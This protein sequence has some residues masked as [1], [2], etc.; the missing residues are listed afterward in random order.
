[1]TKR[2]WFAAQALNGVLAHPTRYRPRRNSSSNW[3]EAIAE[4][5]CELAD[6]LIAELEE[7]E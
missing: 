4:E 7:K 5:A 6:A 2:E 3:H 1:M